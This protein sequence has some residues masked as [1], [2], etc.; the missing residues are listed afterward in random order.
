LG[1]EYIW[2]RYFII[3]IKP[4]NFYLTTSIK[5]DIKETSLHRMQINHDIPFC[6]RGT[7]K[8]CS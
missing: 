8:F 3:V 5:P 6:N 1:I 4:E 7:I 2:G